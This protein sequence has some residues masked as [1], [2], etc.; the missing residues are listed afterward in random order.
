MTERGAALT[1]I[2]VLSAAEAETRL[3]E[4]SDILVEAVALGASVNFMAG[5]SREQGRAFWRNQLTICAR[6]VT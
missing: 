1:S 3:D 4:L 6:L 2:R 5:F